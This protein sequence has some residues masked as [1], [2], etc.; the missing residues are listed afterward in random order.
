MVA[1]KAMGEVARKWE[2]G[3]EVAKRQPR[4]GKVVVVVK[5]CLTAMEAD[6]VA[7]ATAATKSFLWVKAAAA[8]EE[9]EK[10]AA[11]EHRCRWC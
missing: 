6:E 11:A 1:A 10:V 8:A 4:L 9:A 3:E 5:E 7:K 2:Q